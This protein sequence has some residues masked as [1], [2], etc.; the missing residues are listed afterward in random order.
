MLSPSYYP[1]I[2]QPRPYDS[3]SLLMRFSDTLGVLHPA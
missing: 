1:G 3:R 2:D